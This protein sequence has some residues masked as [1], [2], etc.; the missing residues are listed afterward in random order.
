MKVWRSKEA[1]KLISLQQGIPLGRKGNKG[2]R[3]SCKQLGMQPL[4]LLLAGRSV[5]DSRTM[6]DEYSSLQAVRGHPTEGR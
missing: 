2:V 4:Q 6:P 5:E 3:A 1:K